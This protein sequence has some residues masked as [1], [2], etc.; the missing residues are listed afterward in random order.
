M[1]S[2][3]FIDRVLPHIPWEERLPRC[4]YVRWCSEKKSLIAHTALLD[5]N[6][7]FYN[8][9]KPLRFKYVCKSIG[10][11]VITADEKM[12][13]SSGIIIDLSGQ[14]STNDWHLVVAAPI[15]LSLLF[16]NHS[17]KREKE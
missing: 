2:T 5:V 8:G 12:Y 3:K 9:V 13:I 1:A 14:R 4:R 17:N 15:P 6:S 16:W 10:C 7:I 11:F